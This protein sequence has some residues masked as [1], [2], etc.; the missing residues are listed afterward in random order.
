VAGGDYY[1]A[2]VSDLTEKAI[3]DFV[4]RGKGMVGVLLS[5]TKDRSLEAGGNRKK[6]KRPWKATWADIPEILVHELDN[7]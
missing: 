5:T 1:Y 6:P 3:E 2:R 4:P 7:R